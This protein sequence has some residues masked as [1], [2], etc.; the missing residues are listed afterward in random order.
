MHAIWWG[1]RQEL[2]KVL[3]QSVHVRDLVTHTDTEAGEAGEVA[4][5]CSEG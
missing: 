4:L 3:T 1:V 2:V 5:E